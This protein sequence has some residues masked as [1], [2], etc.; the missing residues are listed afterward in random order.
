LR[1]AGKISAYSVDDPDIKIQLFLGG[2]KTVNEALRQALEIQAVFVAARPH[3]NNTNIYRGTDRPPPDDE[4]Q[5]NQNAEA[6]ENRATSRVTAPMKG[7]LIM[8]GVKNMKI[9]QAETRGNHQEGRNGDQVTTK[10]RTGG[11]ANN[12]E[13]ARAGGE[14]RTLAYLL[15]PTHYALTAITE[16]ADPS[17]VAQGW[18]GEKPCLLTV[19]T[20]A[21][22]TVIR[23]DITDDSR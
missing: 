12:R 15:R 6:V 22:V 5:N 4:T 16:N 10:K 21:Y 8:S 9:G 13:P 7:R 23:P 17:L 2:E 14:G 11:V 3:K 1:E 19:D 18:V 20:D